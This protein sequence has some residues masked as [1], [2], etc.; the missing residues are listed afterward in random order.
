MERYTAP[1]PPNGKK[2]A[3]S[4][5]S[6]SGSHS[7]QSGRHGDVMEA[8][9]LGVKEASTH[10]PWKRCFHNADKRLLL[11]SIQFVYDWPR[12]EASC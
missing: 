6:R 1:P 4:L 7:R 10:P 8:V 2:I 3:P 12:E 5:P 9:V 11:K